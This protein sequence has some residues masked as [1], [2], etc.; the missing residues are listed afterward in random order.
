MSL[1]FIFFSSFILLYPTFLNDYSSSGPAEPV[2][3]NVSKSEVYTLIRPYLLT[4]DIFA[5][6]PSLTVLLRV[7][8]FLILSH[9]LTTRAQ[10][11]TI[12]AENC[13]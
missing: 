5:D 2:R 9:D 12:F 7:S 13:Q 6:L 1:A 10:N 8:R 4:D 3:I 11:L